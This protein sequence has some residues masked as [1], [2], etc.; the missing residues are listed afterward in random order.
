[1]KVELEFKSKDDIEQVINY[2]TLILNQLGIV[3]VKK[4]YL[5]RQIDA[6]LLIDLVGQLEEVI[7]VR[8]Q[9]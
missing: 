7:D 9:T 8:S 6:D 4:P 1:M 2:L 5:I 3:R